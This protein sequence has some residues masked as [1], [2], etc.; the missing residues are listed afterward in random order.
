MVPFDPY[1]AGG[2]NASAYRYRAFRVIGDAD[3][4]G[5]TRR[6]GSIN[7]PRPAHEQ[8]RRRA[9]EAIS[10]PAGQG[11]QVLDLIAVDDVAFVV[12]EAFQPSDHASVVEVDLRCGCR[13][14]DVRQNLDRTTD[15]L[16]DKFSRAC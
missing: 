9:R 15:T 2:T 7:R 10:S 3:H 5:Q 13:A 4:S 8:E 11:H 6:R 14:P 1:L 16:M 12:S